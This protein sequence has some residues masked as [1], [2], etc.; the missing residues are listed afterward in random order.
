MRDQKGMPNMIA[1]FI[2]VHRYPEQFKRLFQSI[3]TPGNQYVIHVD[4]SS[5]T[6][7]AADVADFLTPYQGARLLPPQNAVWGGYSLVEA[8]LRGMEMLLKMG[9]SWTHYINL[10]GQDFP[11]K[12]QTYIQDFF[13]ANPDKQ[14]IRALHQ[15]SKRPETMNRLNHYHIEALGE[16]IPTEVPRRFFSDATPYIGTQWKA[17]TRSFCEFVCHNPAVDRFKDFYR[18]SFIADEGFF[19]TVIM[20]H[21][22]QGTIMNDDLRMIDWVPDGI[23]KLRPRNFGAQD[24]AALKRSPDLFARKFDGREDPLIL[25]LL[26]E[27]LASMAAR[28]YHHASNDL[29]SKRRLAMPAAVAA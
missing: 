19:Q 24:I 27:H 22:D 25:G 10:S 12:S 28:T 1:Y 6:E 21:G 23:I 8:E 15:S 2:L 11:L 4:K 18:N 5:G 7:L 16:M 26:E 9:S 29:A 17:V 3:Y 13:A 20:N 14:F